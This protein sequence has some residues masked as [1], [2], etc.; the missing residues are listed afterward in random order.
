M[1]LNYEIKFRFLISL[2]IKNVGCERTIGS[3]KEEKR[4]EKEE[5][6]KVVL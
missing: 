2:F 3:P 4:R 5:S 6:E 1:F